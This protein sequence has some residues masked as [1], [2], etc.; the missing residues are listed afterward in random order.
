[1]FL[2]ADPGQNTLPIDIRSD[3]LRLILDQ[4][5]AEKSDDEFINESNAVE[6]FKISSQFEIEALM[7]ACRNFFVQNMDATNCFGF[8]RFAS[9]Y[10]D[11][12]L[13][14]KACGFVRR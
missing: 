3:Y 9:I 6:I 5:Y 10:F 1:M 4:L 2:Y 13:K 8:W 14:E 7:S 12:K 11:S